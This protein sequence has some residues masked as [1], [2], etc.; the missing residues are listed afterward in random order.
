MAQPWRSPHRVRNISDS[1]P[2][3][4]SLPAIWVST[5]WYFH[6]LEWGFF[7]RDKIRVRQP[8]MSWFP[9]LCLK[10]WYYEVTQPRLR[11]IFLSIGKFELWQSHSLDRGRW[12]NTFQIYWY[13]VQRFVE[14]KPA[15]RKL[16]SKSPVERPSLESHSCNTSFFRR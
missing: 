2:L 10:T 8:K 13:N 4:L 11:W 5:T 6:D 3:E 15:T 7:K 9:C 12:F 14:C 1:D 16:N